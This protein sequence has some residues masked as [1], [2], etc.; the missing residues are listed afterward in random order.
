MTLVLFSFSL[1]TANDCI[2][3]TTVRPVAPGEELCIFYGHTLWFEPAEGSS[4]VVASQ[5]TM[6]PAP[7]GTLDFCD[8][9]DSDGP[10]LDDDPDCVVAERELPFQIYKLSPEEEEIET[11]Y[12]GMQYTSCW[13]MTR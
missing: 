13:N 10:F 3:Y 12:T 1:D 2:K 5:E 9:E 8:A 11:V 4:S 6:N 7:F